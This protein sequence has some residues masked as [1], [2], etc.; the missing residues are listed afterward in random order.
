MTKRTLFVAFA[1]GWL[2]IFAPV[3][4]QADTISVGSFPLDPVPSYL[5]APPGAAFYVP[6][7]ISGVAGLQNWQFT[8]NF[9]NSVVE[10][11]DPF[12]G[13]SGIYGAQFTPGDANSQS[14]I[15]GGFPLNG[16]GIVDTVA[17][18]YPFLPAGPSGDGVLA[19]ILFD[20]LPGQEGN[21]PGFS[22][23]N[24]AVQVPAPAVG[25]GLPG[26]LAALALL[27]GF[28][29]TNRIRIKEGTL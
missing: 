3:S 21:D 2:A 8:L 25:S 5:P 20:F 1:I 12:D 24:V 17:G 22:I 13:S 9:D 14:F 18:S 11:V 29:A 28:F 19:D 7:Q 4:G 16:L 10:V 15:L 26:L 23:T 27:A 6:V